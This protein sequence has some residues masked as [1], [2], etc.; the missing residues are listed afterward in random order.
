V[1]KPYLEESWY[2]RGMAKI[3]LGDQAGGIADL[4]SALR[5]HPGFLPAIEALKTQ[6]ITVNP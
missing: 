5:Y 3:A 1:D 2:W 4:R 6:G